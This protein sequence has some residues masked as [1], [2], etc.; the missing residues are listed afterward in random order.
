MRV[1]HCAR[2]AL[3]AAAF[4]LVAGC[5]TA[6]RKP[7]LAAKV[8]RSHVRVDGVA[9]AKLLPAGELTRISR[10]VPAAARGE[11]A[12]N[13]AVGGALYAHYRLAVAAG[14]QLAP[15][16]R[17]ILAWPPAG[18]LIERTAQGLRIAF[19]V[20]M[21]KGFGIGATALAAPEGQTPQLQKIVPPRV[22]SDNEA[23]LWGARQL[24]FSA[25]FSPCSARYLPVMIPVAAGTHRNID[26]YLLPSGPGRGQIFLGG[27][28]R[29]V[30]NDSGGKILATH[31][32]GKSCHTINGKAAAQGVQTT[33]NGSESPTIPEVFASL[34]YGR[35]V[36]VTTAANGALWKVSNGKIYFVSLT[37]SK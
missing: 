28:Y 31:R 32:F 16:G 12:S 37:G 30:V 24:A 17:S 13:E 10:E 36:Y 7:T 9:L 26:V 21:A 2:L 20:R 8:T 4:A 27:Y 34:R 33:L 25:Q 23:K 19:V 22:L 29:V 1:T 3:G 6:P 5:A 15:H 11:A 14:R 35:P 18:W